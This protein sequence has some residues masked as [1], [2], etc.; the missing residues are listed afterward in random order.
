MTEITTALLT[1]PIYNDCKELLLC[2][3]VLVAFFGRFF[4]FAAFFKRRTLRAK[5]KRE[6]ISTHVG[7]DPPT[8]GLAAR[9]ATTAPRAKQLS[10]STKLCV[11][12]VVRSPYRLGY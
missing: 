3:F 1:N 9:C 11:K 7:F 10:R 2:W 6:K 12:C 5:N 8:F 4:K